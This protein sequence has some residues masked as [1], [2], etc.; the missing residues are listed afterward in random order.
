MKSR[1][2]VHHLLL[3]LAGGGGNGNERQIYLLSSSVQRIQNKVF[4][5]HSEPHHPATGHQQCSGI[6]SNIFHKL[7]GLTFP[8]TYIYYKICTYLAARAAP[9]VPLSTRL[10]AAAVAWVPG[11]SEATT[12]STVQYSTVQYSTVQ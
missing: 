1:E 3:K 2:K 6:N 8:E 10:A 9:R 5:G 12:C 7:E 4:G 11:S